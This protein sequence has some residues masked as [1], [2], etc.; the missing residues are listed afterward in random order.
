MIDDVLYGDGPEDFRQAEWLAYKLERN[1]R[2]DHSTHRWHGWN[3]VRWAPDT[4]MQ[5]SRAVAVAAALAIPD[6]SNDVVRKALI[7]LLNISSID[8]A[9]AALSTFD[10]YGTDGNDW[11]TDPYVLGCENGIVDLRTNTIDLHPSQDTL[12]TK[13]T[14]H[15][16]RPV[17]GPG[18]FAT[19]APEFMKYIVEVMS[20][21]ISMVSFLLLWYGYSLIG[22]NPEQKFLLQIGGGRNGKGKLKDIVLEAGGEYASQVNANMYM[23][24][25]KH[26]GLTSN[27]PRAD[28][29]ALR[30]TRIVFCS[31]PE[32]NSFNEPM[33]KAHTG[34][35]RIRTRNLYDREEKEW[36][37]THNISFLVNHPPEV[38]D[39]GDSF[40]ERVMVADFRESYLVGTKQPPNTELGNILKKEAAGVLAILVWA[41]SEWYK[42]DTPK[43]T[44]PERVKRQSRAF[45]EANDPIAQFVTAALD[46]DPT[47][48]VQSSR[49]YEAYI[50]WHTRTERQE[51]AM[52]TV[53]FSAAVERKHFKKV[54][55][56]SGLRWKGISPKS[57]VELAELDETEDE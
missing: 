23:R 51:E 13:T 49:L 35:D 46:V 55:T 43:L 29:M 30:G 32:G 50:Q 31:D 1:W 15:R 39:V 21:D 38:E 9:L 40:R 12:V 18:E 10:G 7:K 48:T 56:E 33:L 14:H 57:A 17:S 53:K 44:M 34:E 4:T 6:V 25:N 5:V 28:L 37:P 52:S 11:D 16:F 20:G 2:Y 36:E 24:V 41:A 27:I 19:R 3:G 45:V 42:A 8:K 54:R 22:R 26:G 47:Y